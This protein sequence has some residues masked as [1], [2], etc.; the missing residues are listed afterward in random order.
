MLVIEPVSINLFIFSFFLTNSI[1]QM[2]PM[3]ALKYSGY[4][5]SLY[6]STASTEHS[7]NSPGAAAIKSMYSSPELQTSISSSGKYSHL[8]FSTFFN[9][10][11]YFM[12]LTN[13]HTDSSI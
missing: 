11:A 9:S 12:P 1:F 4:M 6:S 10:R 2:N 8:T 5:G 7:L 3:D 13:R